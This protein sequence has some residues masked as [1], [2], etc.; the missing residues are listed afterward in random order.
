MQ[1]FN[2]LLQ[3]SAVVGAVWLLAIPTAQA[4]DFLMIPDSNSDR[5]LLF[6]PFDGSLVNDNFID[7]AGLFSTPLNAIQ[8]NEEIWVSDQVADSIFR[9][10]LSG[11][12]INTISGGLDNIRGMAFVG[13]TVYVSNAGT[14]NGAPGDGEVV[15]TFDTQGNN[16]GFFDTGDPYDI[17]AYN[18]DLLINDINSDANGGEDIDRYDLNGNL[19]GTFHDSD[20]LTG[21][22]F[23]QQMTQRANGNVLVA[24]FSAPGGIYEYDPDGNPVGFFDGNSGIAFRGIRGVYELGNGNILWT[25]GDG[26]VSTD[27]ATGTATDI[28]TVNTPD[29]LPEDGYRPSAR[30]IDKLSI[31]DV[32]DVPEPGMALGLFSLGLLG[33]SQR[34]RQKSA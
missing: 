30:Y 13:D 28:F 2:A 26:V 27:L 4:A 25:G 20:G 14:N 9:F 17:L 10:D 32:A 6:D 5:I 16:L 24:G 18:G 33:L 29:L 21:I 19:L 1:R 11:G 22:D 8:V 31:P 23:P 34:R 15:I 7:G 12:L 3:R